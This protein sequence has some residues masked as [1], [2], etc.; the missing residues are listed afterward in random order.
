M[1][2][3]VNEEESGSVKLCSKC[4][5]QSHKC[6][7][8]CNNYIKRRNVLHVYVASTNSCLYG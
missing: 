5:V 2:M 4:R 3:E 8:S 6:C 1:F 7:C